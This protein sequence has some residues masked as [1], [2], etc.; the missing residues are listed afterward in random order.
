MVVAFT[1]IEKKYLVVSLDKVFSKFSFTNCYRFMLILFYLGDFITM[2][3]SIVINTLTD[4]IS[5]K[6]KNILAL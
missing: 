5:A 4:S 6:R 3:Y 1:I 2:L